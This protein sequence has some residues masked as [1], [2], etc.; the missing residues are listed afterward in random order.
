MV[1]LDA[2]TGAVRAMA[3]GRDFRASQF[4]RATSARRQPGSAFKPFVYLA[5]LE[6]GMRPEDE[7]S[8]APL[9]LGGWSPGN[10]A[11]KPRG[12]ISMEEALAQSVNTAAVRVLFR[13]GGPRAAAEAA[14]RLGL[15]G[16]FPNDAS[17]ALGTGEVTLLDLTAAYAG[18]RQ[19]RA[20]GDPLRHRRR[21]GDRRRPAGAPPGAAPR[22]RGRRM[23]RR[24]GGCW[25]RWCRAAPAAPPRSPAAAS[26]ARPAPPRISATP[27]SSASPAARVIGIWLGNDDARPMD[28]VSG[29]S[30]P[31]RLFHDITESGL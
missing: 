7:V 20:A 25:K 10:G 9:T 30:L 26:P 28:S 14:R 27:G 17:L 19:W 16:R 21:P 31:A 22:H 2:A 8:D 11:W 24:C 3:G 4:N 1:V 15:D 5:A 13:A 29:G 18:L 12:E 23:P 6:K